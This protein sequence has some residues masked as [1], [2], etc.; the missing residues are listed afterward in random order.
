M[1]EHKFKIFTSNGEVSALPHA[2]NVL[3]LGTFDGVHA[4]HAALLSC[5]KD[6]K[7][8]LGDV[9]AGVWCFSDSPAASIIGEKI[10]Q[11]LSLED[12]VDLMLETGIDFVAVADFSDYRDT[13]PQDFVTE[14]LIANLGCVGAVC[15]FN[16][17]F[18]QGGRGDS[19]LLKG[20]LGQNSVIVVDPITYNGETVSS[21]AIREHISNGNIATANKMLSRAYALKAEV[22]KGKKL[23]RKLNFP[24]AN[25]YFPK[26]SVVPKY[27]IYATRC[28]IDGN[29]Y[30][31]VSNVGIRPT[32]TDGSDSH[33][34]NC[35]T[36]ILDFA[37]DL[38][39]K[40][41]TV[42]FHEYL[43]EERK[44]DS[45]DALREQIGRDREASFAY[46]ANQKTTK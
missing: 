31:G 7:R 26:N 32:I 45:V 13:L 25:Q 19:E 2:K 18:G 30:V 20:L 9:G 29:S 24:T 14:V 1:T 27:G 35:E 5:A 10:P 36:Y 15:G 12:K 43:R 3:A 38:Y 42:E 6:L 41:I 33:R 23:G 17:R 28:I 8:E 4:A 11:L 40:E 16:H 37:D 46:F 39:G 34:A 21:T 44:F 22:V